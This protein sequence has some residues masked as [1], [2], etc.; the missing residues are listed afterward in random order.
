PPQAETMKLYRNTGKGTFEDVTKAV[1]LDRVVPTMGA[2]F[3]D[4]DN[5]G[6]LDFYLGTG[7]PSYAAA[8]PKVM[9]RNHEGKY[10]TDVTTSTGTGHLQKGHGISF[11]D[12]NNDGNQDVFINLGG[13]VPGDKYFKALFANPGHDNHWLSVKLIGVKT[14][15]AAIGA[16]IKV[17]LEDSSGK[18]SLRYREVSSGGSFGSNPFTQ[19]IGLGKAARIKTLEIIWPTSK[20]EQVFHDVAMDQFIQV[21]EFEKDYVKRQLK[22]FKLGARAGAEGHHHM[23]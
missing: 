8:M 6:Y 2:N 20:T 7:S 14:N 17:I 18:E 16:K 13:A 10:F 9:Y 11:A 19:S 4:L 12:V 1:G 23:Q 3:G 21:K 15:R 22:T 5:D